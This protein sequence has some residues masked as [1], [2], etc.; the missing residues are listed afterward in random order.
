MRIWKSVAVLW[1]FAVP[2]MAPANL[3]ST[4]ITMH[5][6]AKK[7][8]AWAQKPFGLPRADVPEALSRETSITIN[9]GGQRLFHS[10]VA[11]ND[12]GIW[13]LTGFC[14]I[15]KHLQEQSSEWRLS[16]VGDIIFREIFCETSH[17]VYGLFD[18]VIDVRIRWGNDKKV[19][20]I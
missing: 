13:A 3:E 9:L 20:I 14:F 4:E 16:S 5:C 1:L 11:T 17:A 15:S 7:P 2:F 8:E 10:L 12:S 19:K 6:V 18:Q